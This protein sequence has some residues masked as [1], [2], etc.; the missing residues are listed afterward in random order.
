M[1]K[2]LFLLTSGLLFSATVAN[3]QYKAEANTWSV[4]MNYSPDKGQFEIGEYGA[5]V[6]YH[7]SDNLALRL[8][9]GISTNNKISTTYVTDSDDK[10]QENNKKYFIN[11]FA[12]MPGIE[13]HFN[14]FERVSPYIGGELGFYAGNEGTKQDNSENDNYNISKTP[15]FGFGINFVSGFDV[16]VCKGLYLGAE[17]GLGYDY[18][19]L[20]RENIEESNGDKV[21][22]S[23]GNSSESQHVF[24]FSVKP[25]IRIGW[26]F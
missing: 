18:N 12:L 5:R 10:E 9:L 22:T 23:E 17:L 11:R 25:S 1:K 21:E 20:G 14:K 16:Y 7:L 4:E 26:N 8:N 2:I 24:G 13:Y 6:R 19:S 15:L 3:A